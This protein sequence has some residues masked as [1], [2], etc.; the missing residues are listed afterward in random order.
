MAFFGLSS[1]VFSIVFDVFFMNTTAGS[2]IGKNSVAFV[3]F[4]AVFCGGVD[5]LCSTVVGVPRGF[6]LPSS[7][8]FD[9]I[10]SNNAMNINNESSRSVGSMTDD[11]KRAFVT[12]NLTADDR[13]RW[14]LTITAIG[15]VHVAVSGYLAHQFGSQATSPLALFIFACIAYSLYR[16]TTLGTNS[17]LHHKSELVAASSVVSTDQKSLEMKSMDT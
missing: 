7:S 1:G 15:A 5:I 2:D 3:Q 8:A 12:G 6:A 9:E 17:L 10:N 4:L 13:L 14:S 16:V 11:V